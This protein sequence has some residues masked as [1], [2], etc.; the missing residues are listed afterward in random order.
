M[1]IMNPMGKPSMLGLQPPAQIRPPMPV[2]QAPP[3]PMNNAPMP[4]SNPSAM[5]SSLNDLTPE[6][7]QMLMNQLQQMQGD[8]S[9]MT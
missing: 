4:M 1:G 9:L 3:I 2:S 8:G 6:Q 5:E 7:I